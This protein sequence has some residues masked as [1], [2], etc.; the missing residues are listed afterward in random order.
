[1]ADTTYMPKTYTTDG[2]DKIVIVSGG[3]ITNDGTQAATIADGKTD[4][5]QADVDDAAAINGTEIAVIFN[6]LTVQINAILLA[7]EGVGILADS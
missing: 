7:L 3:S 6:L 4:Y 1:M 5:A 2:G